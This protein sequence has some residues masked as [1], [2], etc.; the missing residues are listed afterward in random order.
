MA[1][2]KRQTPELTAEDLKLMELV[3]GHESLF[4]R[5]LLIER[6]FLEDTPVNK[7]LGFDD[8]NQGGANGT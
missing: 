2:V 5:Q 4:A 6:G 1:L 8:V 3:A 7:Q